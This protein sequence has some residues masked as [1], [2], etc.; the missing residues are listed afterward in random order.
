MVGKRIDIRYL[1]I[2]DHDVDEIGV[3]AHVLRFTDKD[4]HHRG[5]AGAADLHDLFL[6][7]GTAPQ[8]NDATIAMVHA[9]AD[10]QLAARTVLLTTQTPEFL[11]ITLVGRVVSSG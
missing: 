9:A 6:R 2:A 11:N 8:S 10:R 7:L 5:A 3:G 4:N 1:R